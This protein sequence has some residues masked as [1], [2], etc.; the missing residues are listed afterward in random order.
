MPAVVH[1]VLLEL[2]HITFFVFLHASLL[3]AKACTRRLLVWLLR[4]RGHVPRNTAA[5][6]P[7]DLLVCF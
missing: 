7:G 6:V 3:R 1:L 2:T 4:P 5:Q